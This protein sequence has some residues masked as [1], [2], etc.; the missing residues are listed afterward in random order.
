[1]RRA[2]Q[3]MAQTNRGSSRPSGGNSKNTGSS[4][5]RGKKR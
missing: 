5:K 1:M 4:S 2:Q 3:R